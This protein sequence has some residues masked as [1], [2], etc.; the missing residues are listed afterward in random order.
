MTGHCTG[1]QALSHAQIYF[2]TEER[3]QSLYTRWALADLET[4]KAVLAQE[5]EE[6]RQDSG[7]CLGPSMGRTLTGGKLSGGKIIGIL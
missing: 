4:E 2:R 5:M 1:I 6:M 7:R 3:F